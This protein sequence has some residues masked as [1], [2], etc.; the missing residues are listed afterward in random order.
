MQENSEQLYFITQLYRDFLLPT[1]LGD[2]N[3]Q[4]LYWA[5]KRVARK[6]SLS[7]QDD[8][9]EFFEMANLGDL[10]LIK[11]KRTQY[12]FELGGQ[13]ISDRLASDSKE[14]SLES[15]ILAEA[16]EQELKQPAAGEATIIDNKKIVQINV[17]LD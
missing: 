14:F 6:Y 8:I 4:I 2:D 9:A 1:I 13:I 17:F 11:E 10:K 15:G 5:G 16:L 3:A 7:S 12:T